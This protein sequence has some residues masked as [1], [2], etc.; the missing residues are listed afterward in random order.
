ML[1]GA[2]LGKGVVLGIVLGMFAAGIGGLVIIGRQGLE[3][4]KQTMPLGPFLA[5]GAV[6][7]RFFSGSDF[8]S[9]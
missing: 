4:R 5:Q 8:V 6:I 3:A 2:G 7:S 9:F 1:L